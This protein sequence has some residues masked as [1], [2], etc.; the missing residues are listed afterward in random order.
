LSPNEFEKSISLR[1]ATFDQNERSTLIFIHGYNVKFSEAAIRAAQIGFDLKVPGVMA[2]YSWPSKAVVGSYLADSDS[3]ASSET[4]LIEFI[5]RVAKASGNAKLNII[6]HSMGNL[7][8]IRALTAGFADKRL[9]GVKFGQIFLA[10]PDIVVNLFKLLAKVYPQCSERTTLY[11][12]AVDNALLVSR[13]LHTNQRTG[14]SPP[15][16]VVDGIDTVEATH[17]DLGLL[18]HGYYAGSAPVLYDMATLIRGN[19]APDKRSGLF[20]DATNDGKYWVIR[21]HK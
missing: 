11:I 15:V 20:P 19:V 14:Y 18:G 4:Y 21:P 3:I 5:N 9:E 6:A 7:G 17:I 13:L 1:L 2:L 10:A 16:T 12:S 8:L